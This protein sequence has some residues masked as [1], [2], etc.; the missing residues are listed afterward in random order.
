ML[1]WWVCV[2]DGEMLLQLF[3][4]SGE[5]LLLSCGRRTWVTPLS[6]T[7]RDFHAILDLRTKHC[8][9]PDAKGSCTEQNCLRKWSLWLSLLMVLSADPLPLARHF[10]YWNENEGWEIIRSNEAGKQQWR[11]GFPGS[12][13]LRSPCG[14]A[15]AWRRGVR[16]TVSAAF[17][18]YSQFVSQLLVQQ[19]HLGA[20]L[21]FL[22]E[23]PTKASSVASLFLLMLLCHLLRPTATII[24]LRQIRLPHV[25]T[26]N[27]QATDW[28]CQL[29]YPT[30]YSWFR[31]TLL[32]CYTAPAPLCGGTS[33]HFPTYCAPMGRPPVVTVALISSWQ[34]VPSWNTQIPDVSTAQ[35]LKFRSSL[36]LSFLRNPFWVPVCGRWWS[37]SLL[38]TVCKLTLFWFL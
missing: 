19:H 25:H 11:W 17:T 3:L 4:V 8:Q 26:L 9:A 28:A 35:S 34:P 1:P 14:R 20:A 12:T 30:F 21:P 18:V 24:V 5:R 38:G 27:L 13:W 29:Q 15:L 23:V 37:P 31:P 6:K 33:D 32:P 2:R 36:Q 16:V 22:Q 7:F 10:L